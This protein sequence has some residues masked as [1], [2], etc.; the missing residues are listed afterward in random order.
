[1]PTTEPFRSLA[2]VQLA[3]ARL[4][5]ERDRTQDALRTHFDHLREPAFR[6]ALVGATIGELLQAWP[7]IKRLT[8]LLGGSSGITSKALG[9]A[10]GAKATTPWGRAAMMVASALLPGLVE[11]LTADPQG[12]GQRVL[13]ELG[14]SWQRIKDHVQARAEARRNTPEA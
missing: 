6:R 13:H 5:T 2:D 12:T 1:M 9:L 7:P 3:K 10:L 11:R 4:R 8:R 14:I